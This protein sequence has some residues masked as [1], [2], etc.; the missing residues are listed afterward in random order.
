M[1]SFRPT[2]LPTSLH[3][4]IW[5]EA[6]EGAERINAKYLLPW[7]LQ[8]AGQKSADPNIPAPSLQIKT[9]VWWREKTDE[10][11]YRPELH[12]QTDSTE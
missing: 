7:L 12:V 4:L 8:V 10:C 11:P 9:Y 1:V 6:E 3:S 2:S 5:N